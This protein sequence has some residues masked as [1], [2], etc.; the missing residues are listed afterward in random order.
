MAGSDRGAGSAAPPDIEVCSQGYRR[1]H[2]PS[3]RSGWQGW[4]SH[5]L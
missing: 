5:R 2:D 4:F 3:L 1:N